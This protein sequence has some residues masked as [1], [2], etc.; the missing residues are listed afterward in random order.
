MGFGEKW[1]KCI[2]ECVSSTWFSILVNGSPKC[3]FTAR[4]GLGQGD[5]LSLF[6]FLIMAEAL[7]RMIKEAVCTGLFEGFKVDR[8]TLAINHLQF[9]N[10]TFFVELK[11]TK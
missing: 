9:A 10:D 7:G 1:R 4:K 6:L 5:P 2:Q 11:K 8:N 3:F